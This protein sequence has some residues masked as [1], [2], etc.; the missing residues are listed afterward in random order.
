MPWGYSLGDACGARVGDV[1]DRTGADEVSSF[2]AIGCRAAVDAHLDDAFGAAGGLDHAPAFVDGQRE[3]FPHIH[4]LAGV[5]GVDRHQGVP[6]VGGG[7]HNC[8]NGGPGSDSQSGR[9]S[10][11]DWLGRLRRT[12]GPGVLVGP[13]DRVEAAKSI[14][15]AGE[16][17]AAD[18]QARALSGVR[19]GANGGRIPRPGSQ[20]WRLPGSRSDR[21][22]SGS[23]AIQRCRLGSGVRAARALD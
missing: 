14:G 20:G 23:A 8:I 4:I 10:G 15:K 17:G 3:R 7:D 21:G 12:R 6:M 9:T 13:A 16:R 11:R 2:L 18:S 1:S 19:R 22:L 5:A